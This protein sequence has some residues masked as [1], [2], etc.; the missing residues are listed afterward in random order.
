MYVPALTIYRLSEPSG[1]QVD[2]DDFV[3]IPQ[4]ETRQEQ[5]ITVAG[6]QARLYVRPL[7]SK[8]PTRAPFLNDAF[9]VFPV[10]EGRHRRPFS[11]SS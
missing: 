6:F 8:P 3:Q 10:A 2:F 11:C 5:T 1:G 9:G 7:D 4:S